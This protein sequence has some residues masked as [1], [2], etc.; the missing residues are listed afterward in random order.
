MNIRFPPPK[1]PVAAIGEASPLLL[2]L[3]GG[4]AD[5]V[6]GLWPAP[7]A[8]YMLLP[9]ERRH[10]VHLWLEFDRRGLDVRLMLDLPARRLIPAVLPTPPS[11]LVRALARLGELA[12]VGADYRLLIDRLADPATAKVLRHA[13]TLSA[14]AVRRVAALP[15][16]LL[17]AGLGRLLFDG[18][19]AELLA[20]VYE[21]IL[22][23]DGPS[24]AAQA[25]LRWGRARDLPRLYARVRKDLEL[26]VYPQPFP[27]S[28][29]LRPLVT[30]AAMLDGA[31][32]YGNCLAGET[33]N[34]AS[35]WAAFLEWVGPPGVVLELN[36]D[37]HLGWR[38]VQA[39][40]R[41]NTAVPV[42]QRA[43]I[44]A[45]LRQWGVRVG[46]AGWELERDLAAPAAYAPDPGAAAEQLA[47]VFGD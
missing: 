26:A 15:E 9:A 19:R 45:E 30:K 4:Y 20:E 42:E 3:A 36:R 14:E 41:G 43:E 16:P 22:Q 44:V 13:P 12:W 33:H 11:G 10:L 8:P 32:R 37:N 21:A 24:V 27:G 34:A 47:G 40:A 38:L 31:Q 23:R 35:G 5:R 39:R 17:R 25:A 1:P 29:R 7:H 2:H 46:R 28:P 18:G 6:A